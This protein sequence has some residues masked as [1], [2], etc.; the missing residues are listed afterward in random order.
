MNTLILDSGAFIA[1]ERNDPKVETRLRRAFA[2]RMVVR[3]TG[4][5]I[6]QVWRD[7]NGRQARLAQLLEVV[8]VEPIDAALGKKGGML[9]AKACKGDAVDATLV[10]SAGHGDTILT[11]D[12]DDIEPLAAASGKLVRVDA[13]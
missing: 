1:W 5:V 8:R 11:S 12:P 4:A 6:A 9:L 2:R 3:T 7:P 13:W 10:A